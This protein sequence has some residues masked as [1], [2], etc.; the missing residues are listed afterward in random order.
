MPAQTWL[1]NTTWTTNRKTERFR[2]PNLELLPT[3]F[4]FLCRIILINSVYRSGSEVRCN[5]LAMKRP[6]LPFSSPNCLLSWLYNGGANSVAQ[7]TTYHGSFAVLWNAACDDLIKESPRTQNVMW[8]NLFEHN[9]TS[10]Q[11]HPCIT[12]KWYTARTRNLLIQYRTCTWKFWQGNR[13]V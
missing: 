13:K 9:V 3:D 2:Y 11:C 4:T 10:F 8:L 5:S 6:Q 12:G 1:A 7:C